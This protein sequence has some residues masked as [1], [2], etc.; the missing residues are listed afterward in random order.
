MERF[1][2]R[3]FNIP[4]YKTKEELELE[5]NIK[6]EYK[7]FVLGGRGERLNSTYGLIEFNSQEELDKFAIQFHK[8]RKDVIIYS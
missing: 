2:L 3:I 6:G 1:I 7:T 4:N 8:L 5:F